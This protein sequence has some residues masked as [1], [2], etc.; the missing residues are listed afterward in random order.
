MEAQQTLRCRCGINDQDYC[1][2]KCGYVCA[3]LPAE[4]AATLSHETRKHWL[5]ANA[6]SFIDMPRNGKTLMGVTV[7]WR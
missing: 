1:V 7:T 6:E 5:A 3:K 4:F 2:N